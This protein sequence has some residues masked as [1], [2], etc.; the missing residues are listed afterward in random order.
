M[1]YVYTPCAVT[2]HRSSISVVLDSYIQCKC[3]S[4][5]H[6]TIGLDTV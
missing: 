3:R 5:L 1:M 2:V 6:S 4:V